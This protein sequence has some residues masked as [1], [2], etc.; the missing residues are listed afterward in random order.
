MGTSIVYAW[1]PRFCVH[2]ATRWDAALP[3]HPPAVSS[4]AASRAEWLPAGVVCRS[5]W[6]LPFLSLACPVS[7]EQYHDQAATRECSVVA[8]RI[9]TPVCSSAHTGAPP[10]P[11]RAPVL[12]KDWPRCA[13]RRRW[14]KVVRSEAVDVMEGPTTPPCSPPPLSSVSCETVM[15]RA[16]RAHWCLSWEQ[17]LASNTRPSN[18][19]RL[20]VTLH[21]RP[22]TFAST[23]GFDL[24]ATA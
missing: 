23:F 18:A 11:P 14:L 9:F 10:A 1:F 7:R 2:V 12:W 24:L 8:A 16:E 15:T 17:R 21:G 6:P 5:H 4:R 3:C 19:P 20:V 22:S 13:I